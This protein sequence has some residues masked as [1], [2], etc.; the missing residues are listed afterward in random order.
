MIR[1]VAGELRGR[2]LAVGPGVRPTTERAREALFSILGERVRGARVLDAAAGSGALGFEALSRGAREAVFVDADRRVARVLE[3]NV[4]SARLECRASI[5]VRTV[6]TFLSLDRPAGFDVVF[7]GN[8]GTFDRDSSVVLDR[9]GALDQAR[10]VADALG[11]R[12][13]LSEP[14]SNLYL[15]VTVVLG[16]DWQPALPSEPEPEQEPDRRRPWW[17]PRGWVGR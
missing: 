3:S 17:D 8:A 14:D 6:A 5:V 9:M 4:L 11:I 15:D 13:L 12:S 7:F 10:N 2:R 16:R 1:I